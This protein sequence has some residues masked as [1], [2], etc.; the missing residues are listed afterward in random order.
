MAKKAV[1]VGINDYPGS[2]NDLSGCVNDANDWAELLSNK[3]QF[4]NNVSLLTDSSATK[5]KILEALGDLVS[6]AKG[7]DVVVFTYSGH[8]TWVY[9]QGERDES[10]NR[11]EAICAYDGNILDDEIRGIIRQIEPDAHLT[12]ISDS[13]HSGTVTR[14]QLEGAYAR[15]HRRTEEN[16]PKPR[17]MPPP[18]IVTT[19]D[20]LITRE[21]PIRRRFL[22]PESSMPE[23][24]LTGCNARQYSYDAFIDGRFNGAMTAFT[25]RLIKSNPSQTYQELHKQLRQVLPNAQ[26][27]QSPQLEGSKSNISR[28]L[29]T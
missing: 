13:C 2:N 17:Y 26:Y 22:Y 28:P 6:N 19:A 14:N 20:A 10:D 8:G 16:A 12:I 4:G 3:F 24:L 23:V 1:C 9:D 11:D 18:N 15:E 5:S 7:G 25:I 21:M 29:F 27:P